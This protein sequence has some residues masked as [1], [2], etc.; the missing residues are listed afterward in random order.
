MCVTDSSTLPSQT[1]IVN[2][3]FVSTELPQESDLLSLVT[4][5]QNSSFIETVALQH[6]KT[7]VD[8]SSDRSG[9]VT[10]ASPITPSRAHLPLYNFPANLRLAHSDRP[11]HVMASH[12]VAYIVSQVMMAASNHGLLAHT[13]ACWPC[14][15]GEWRSIGPRRQ[16][17]RHGS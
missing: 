11:L 6:G 12:H 15:S 9:S 5:A 8:V 1:H 4:G 17:S 16:G 13:K 3:Y 7:K 10:G 14:S 2:A